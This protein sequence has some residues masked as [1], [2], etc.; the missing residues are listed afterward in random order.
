MNPLIRKFE[1]K[2]IEKVYGLGMAVPEFSVKDETD[3][4]FW[5]KD[6]LEKFV[7]QGLSL[8]IEDQSLVVGFLLTVYQ[9]ITQKLTWENMYINPA[10]QKMGLAE[11][12]FQKTWEMAKKKGAIM[13]EALIASN[14]IPAQKMC[15]R[16]GFK[17]AGNYQW[18]LKWLDNS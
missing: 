7:D 17:G 4:R 2:D 16:L 18:M 5:S 1:S 13:A 15:G 8:V 14:N 3:H 11:N 10:Y 12:C 6:T 9:P